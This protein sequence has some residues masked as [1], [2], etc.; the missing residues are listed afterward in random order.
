MPKLIRLPDTLP[1]LIKVLLLELN[2]MQKEIE[3]LK[4]GT[5]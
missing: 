5:P 3:A 1:E 2:R 4:R